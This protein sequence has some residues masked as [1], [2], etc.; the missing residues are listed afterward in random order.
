MAGNESSPPNEHASG[1]RAAQ[2]V[3]NL[4]LHQL[5]YLREVD[6]QGSLHRAAD[7]LHLS[8]PALSQSLAELERRIGV[9]LFE[10]SGRGRRATV[11]GQELIQFANEVLAQAEVLDRR[12]QRYRGGEGGT[13]SVGMIDAVSLYVLPDVVRRFR[14]QHPAVDLKLAVAGSGEL[15]QRLRTFALDLAFVVGPVDEP[16]LRAVEVLREPLYLYSA[17]AVEGGAATEAWVLYPE[18]SR[19]RAIIDAAL[20]AAGIKPTVTLESGNPQVLRQMVAMGLGRSVLPP[21]IA[22]S[23][24]PGAGGAGAVIRGELVA[25]R[26]LCLVQRAGSPPD[27]RSDAFLRL[28]LPSAP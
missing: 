10:R 21:A 9:P 5:A 7:T 26:P 12:M 20:A 16:G 4:H 15:L 25:E 24:R 6:R 13:L 19:T 8:Q 1:K 14:E 22:E 11:A 23:E 2:T 3:L 27:P 17:P 28:A 18:G